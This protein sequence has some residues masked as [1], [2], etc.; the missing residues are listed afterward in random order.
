MGNTIPNLFISQSPAIDDIFENEIFIPK[1]PK[2]II[3]LPI[4]SKEKIKKELW[5]RIDSGMKEC[6]SLYKEKDKHIYKKTKVTNDRKHIHVIER[7]TRCRIELPYLMARH[8]QHMDE[9]TN[10][11]YGLIVYVQNPIE[12]I[13]YFTMY[14]LLKITREIAH[15][16]DLQYHMD[17]YTGKLKMRSTEK[18]NYVLI[19]FM[20]KHTESCVPIS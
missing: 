2:F 3:E 4:E 7:E 16:N 13:E 10:I 19:H 12:P 6:L 11:Q 14:D 20:G 18:H 17:K 9:K 1:D 8:P 15:E 5:R